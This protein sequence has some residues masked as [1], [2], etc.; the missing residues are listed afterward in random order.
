M[1]LLQASALPL[2]HALGSWSQWITVYEWTILRTFLLRVEET[3]LKTELPN[4][5]CP[6]GGQVKHFLHFHCLFVFFR[7]QNQTNLGVQGLWVII[8]SL[9]CFDLLTCSTIHSCCQSRPF[10][11]M[12]DMENVQTIEM[13]SGDILVS[14]KKILSHY[15]G[16][17]HQYYN[18]KMTHFMW[19]GRWAP[20]KME[21]HRNVRI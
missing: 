17:S 13:K 7:K 20:A 21:M 16:F 15:H 8:L 2:S 12:S 1:K 14:A 18:L 10:N 6:T 3:C 5:F 19:C 4:T 9:P 11:L